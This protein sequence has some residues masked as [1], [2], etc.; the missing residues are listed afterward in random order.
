[1]NSSEIWDAV[2]GCEFFK[3]LEKAHIQK[4]VDLARVIDY[5]PGEY[6][7]R[8]GESGDQIYIIN[9]GHI[10]LERKMDLG[11]RRA[12]VVIGTPGKGKVLGCWTTLLGRPHTYMSSAVCQKRTRAIVLG[13]SSLRAMMLTHTGMGF[14]VL[15]NLC[16]MLRERIEGVYG[17][18]E[19]L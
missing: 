13:G 12:S 15:E 11:E 5:E 3:S 14:S 7:Y 8:Q 9:E 1:M 6:I 18:M 19:K 2:E 10:H 16:L 4:I 17:A